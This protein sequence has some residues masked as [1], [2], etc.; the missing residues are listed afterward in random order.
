MKETFT[1]L[2]QLLQGK[3]E[4]DGY[5]KFPTITNTAYTE[6]LEFFAD[7]DKDAIFFNQKTWY[8]NETGNNGRTVFW[9]TGFIILK[10][11]TILLHSVQVGGRIEM[12][13]LTAST[14]NKFIFNTTAI[15]NDIKTIQAQRIFSVDEHQLQ[16]ELNMVTHEAIFQN[17][18]TA[19]LRK[20]Q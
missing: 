16:Y 3:W 5:A 18:L 19:N 8:K 6:H 7:D 15:V 12:L 2:R 14:A 13:T 20:V 10:N 9:D 1:A 17:H 4:G 11:D